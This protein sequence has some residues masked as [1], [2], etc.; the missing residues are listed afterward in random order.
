MSPA[1]IAMQSSA[2]LVNMSSYPSLGQT[3]RS[4]IMVCSFFLLN[5]FHKITSL[6]IYLFMY[7]VPLLIY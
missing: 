6:K 3:G 4:T 2:P 5:V 7:S 1:N